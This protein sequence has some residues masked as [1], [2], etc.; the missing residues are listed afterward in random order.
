MGLWSGTIAEGGGWGS[1]GS[2][3]RA[4]STARELQADVIRWNKLDILNYQSINLATGESL[5][6]SLKHQKPFYFSK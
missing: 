6:L 3:V 5:G 4:G 2:G 1:G